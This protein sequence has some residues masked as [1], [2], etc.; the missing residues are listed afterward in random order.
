MPN[1]RSVSRTSNTVRLLVGDKLYIKEMVKEFKLTDERF[2]NETN[3]IRYFVHLGIAAQTATENLRKSLDNTIVKHSIKEAVRK[4]LSYHSDHIEKLQNLIT[5]LTKANEKNFTDIA[6]RTET[7]EDQI[8][9]SHNDLLKLLESMFLTG[10]QALRNM[11]VLRTVTYVF[12]LGHKTGQ[13]EA[14]TDNFLKWKQIIFMAHDKA[15]QLSIDEVKMLSAEELEAEVI[16]KMA[17]DIFVDVRK[18]I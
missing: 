15:N 17:S 5:E 3:A 1:F 13:I 18:L 6:R 14:G 2:R 9:S 16:K 12:L 10:E 11:I 7:I 8:Q 4:E